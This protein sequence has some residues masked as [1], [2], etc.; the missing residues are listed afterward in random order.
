[1]NR[2][3]RMADSSM[4]RN[5]GLASAGIATLKAAVGEILLQ[6]GIV[7]NGDNPWD[8]RV[9]DN[10][11]YPRV[12]KDGSLGLGESYMEGWWDCENLD[13]FFFRL[14]P[15]YPEEKVKKNWKML[16][17]L[18]RTVILNASRKSNAFT[19][20][21]KHYD[22]GNELYKKML[23]KRMVY[24]CGYWKDAQNL[25]DAQEAKLDLICR[26]LG[27]RAGDRILDIGCGWGSLIKYASEKYGVSALGVTVSEEQAKLAR[28]NCRGLEVEIRL[29][30]YRDISGKFDHVVSVGMI[31][32]VGYKNY[33]HYMEIVHKS[34]KDDGLFLLHTI[35]NNRSEITGDIWVDKYI[36]PNSMLPSIKQIADSLEGLFVMEDLH[37]FGTH[38]DNTLCAW[39]NNFEKNWHELKSSYDERFHRM[40]RYYLQCFAGAFRSRF[41][42]VWQLVLSKKGVPGGYAA[43][44]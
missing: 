25:D 2:T 16:L 5:S 38:Y 14:L 17:Y 20:G 19:I 18:F 11:F 9:R 44:R 40:W 37:N 24:S 35:G 21:R 7:I 4:R 10:R 1:M 34:L 43:I 41:F 15:T 29:L 12:L 28:E 36:F 13:K 31:E 26:K 27:L 23:D 6:A 30:D 32:H 39:L 22:V 8:I 42:N 3:V 33:R